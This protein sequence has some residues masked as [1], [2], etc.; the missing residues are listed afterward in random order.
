MQKAKWERKDDLGVNDDLLVYVFIIIPNIDVARFTESEENL[1]L[2][3]I[4]TN[5]ESVSSNKV[6]RYN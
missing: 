4:S 5:D 6:T 2:Q 1:G 3:S